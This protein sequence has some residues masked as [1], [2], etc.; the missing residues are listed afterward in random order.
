[1]ERRLGP[2]LP[3]GRSFSVVARPESAS[4]AVG[5]HTRH[6]LEQEQLIHEALGQPIGPARAVRAAGERA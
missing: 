2:L 4:P 3:A 6:D 5:S 1:M